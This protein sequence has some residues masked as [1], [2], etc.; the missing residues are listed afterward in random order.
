LALTALD[1][2]NSLPKEQ[3][4]EE[5]LRYCG[6]RAWA[7]DMAASR[8]FHD[9]AALLEAADRIWWSLTPADWLEAFRAHPRIGE[10]SVHADERAARWSEQEQAGARAAGADAS[11]ALADGN[12]VYEQRFGHIFLICATGL[13]AEEMLANLRARMHNDPQMELRVAA[14][15][16]RKI[17]RIRLE[18]LTSP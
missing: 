11:A 16:Q 12:R 3:A 15:E 10:R 4:E 2:L 13:S 9:V 14:E 1:R 5:L 8:P 18:E 7:W 17:T 6:A